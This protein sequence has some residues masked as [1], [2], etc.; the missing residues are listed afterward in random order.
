MCASEASKF[1]DYLN[2]FDE[3]F[4]KISREYLISFGV[5]ET[6]KI[7]WGEKKKEKRERTRMEVWGREKFSTKMHWI[8]DFYI[9]L[10]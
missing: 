9:Q 1:G 6:E 3:R 4:K 10:R 2:I 5:K 8:S 7:N